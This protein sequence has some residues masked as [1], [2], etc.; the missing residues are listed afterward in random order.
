MVTKK[1]ATWS[2]SQVSKKSKDK[3][4]PDNVSIDGE[5]DFTVE[6]ETSDNTKPWKPQ[7]VFPNRERTPSRGDKS[8]VMKVNN[9]DPHHTN[10]DV[11]E[12]PFL[13]GK[14]S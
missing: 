2:T 9:R 7:I 13:D 4:E 5:E 3:S 14:F 8:V 10:E 6:V 11:E 1:P 12:T